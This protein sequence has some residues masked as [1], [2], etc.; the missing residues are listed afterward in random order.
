MLEVMSTSMIVLPYRIGA[1]SFVRPV[2]R[3]AE[4]LCITRKTQTFEKTNEYQLELVD[5]DG[6]LF[7]RVKNFEMVKIDRLPE[8]HRILDLIRPAMLEKAS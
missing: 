2:A 6:Q 8:K 3:G 5:P 4:Y 7:I 1:M